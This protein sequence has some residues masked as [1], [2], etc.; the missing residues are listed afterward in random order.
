MLI[1]VNSIRFE[2]IDKKQLFMYA[3]MQAEV[4]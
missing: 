4:V 1:F 3:I 2:Y